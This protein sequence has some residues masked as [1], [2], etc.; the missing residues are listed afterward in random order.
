[1]ALES[2]PIHCSSSRVGASE[3]VASTGGRLRP[4]SQAPGKDT[5][6]T[7]HT[8]RRSQRPR[9][10]PWSV[11]EPFSFTRRPNF[12]EHED[13]HLLVVRVHYSDPDRS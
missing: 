1:M 8:Y 13:H 9:R 5:R 11:P 10:E 7:G 3:V 4:A 6:R 12:S 2:R